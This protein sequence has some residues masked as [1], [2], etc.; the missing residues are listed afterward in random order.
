L[1]CAVETTGSFE[2]NTLIVFVS[3]R[4]FCGNPRFVYIGDIRGGDDVEA[5]P[6]LSNANTHILYLPVEFQPRAASR[7]CVRIKF[8]FF[9]R[10]FGPGL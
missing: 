4:R 5:L 8:V 1:A 9:P 7:P 10:S 6:V 3:A 2:Y